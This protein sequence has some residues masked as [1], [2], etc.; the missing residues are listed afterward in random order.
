MPAADMV[1]ITC[2]NRG[3]HDGIVEARFASEEDFKKHS[4]GALMSTEL[5]LLPT[6]LGNMA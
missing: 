6:Y 3:Q 2:I 1:K 4:T 5:L